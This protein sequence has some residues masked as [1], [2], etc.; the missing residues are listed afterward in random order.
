MKKIILVFL[1]VIL[2]LAAGI[3]AAEKSELPGNPFEDFM[4]RC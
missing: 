2:T 3:A 1:A 4:R